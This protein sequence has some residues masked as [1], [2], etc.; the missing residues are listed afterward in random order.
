VAD[1][2]TVG[3]LGGT[4][5]LG[6]ALARR[7]AAGG[8]TVTIGSRE[9]SRA[10]DR[11]A[12]LTAGLPADAGSITGGANAD[13]ATAEVVVAAIPTAGAGE[14]VGP[15][16]DQLAGR[17]LVSTLSPL[18]FDGS[19]PRP[20]RIE[21]GS[22]AE[23]L[24]AAAPTARVVA[25]F[26]TVAAATLGDLDRPLSE[27]VLVCGDDDDALEV[28]RQLIDDRLGGA[29]GVVVGPLRLAS[30]LEGM[31]A[32]LIATNRRHRA[33]TGVRLTGLDG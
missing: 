1:T 11:A 2:T 5:A 27:D 24:A 8:C 6:A 9:P 23:L 3:I 18:E 20:A 17:V 25:G 19:G 7:L 22:A 31:T 28:V 29:R 21:A 26:H 10:V 30:V 16:A 32:V 4:G 13:A 33:H 12:E 15:L 14:L